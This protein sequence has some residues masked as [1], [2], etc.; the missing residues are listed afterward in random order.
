[1]R[2]DF[3]QNQNERFAAD[4]LTIPPYPLDAAVTWIQDN[5]EPEDVFTLGQLERWA[6]DN[7]FNKEIE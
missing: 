1:M 4:A 6:F 5:L 2:I 7:G 3:N